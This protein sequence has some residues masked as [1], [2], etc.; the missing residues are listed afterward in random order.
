MWDC[1]VSG[2]VTFLWHL[3]HDI[4]TGEDRF[5][6]EPGGL[7]LQPLIYNVLHALQ[8]SFP[9]EGGGLAGEEEVGWGGGG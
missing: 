6:V 3:L 9:G 7:H 1:T 4:L 5:Q 8:L 2:G